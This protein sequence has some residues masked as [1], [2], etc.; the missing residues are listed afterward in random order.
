MELL[1]VYHKD[2]DQM[3][4]EKKS[5]RLWSILITPFIYN[6]NPAQV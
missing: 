6:L 3:E 1:E 2:T 5:V 4:E